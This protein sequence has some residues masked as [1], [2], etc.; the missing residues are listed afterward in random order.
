MPIKDYTDLFPTWPLMMRK[1]NE[2]IEYWRDSLKNHKQWMIVA[3][4]VEWD[5]A[6]EQGY[7][8]N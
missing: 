4:I 6:K 1:P 5:Y 3:A 7:L 2:T 8:L